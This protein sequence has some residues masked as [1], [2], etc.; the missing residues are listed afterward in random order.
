[1]V[2]EKLVSL[3]T[4]RLTKT[5]ITV[6]ELNG[7]LRYWEQTKRCQFSKCL[8]HNQESFG[9][10]MKALRM[11]QRDKQKSIRIFWILH[12]YYFHGQINQPPLSTFKFSA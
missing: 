6:I 11:L 10:S 5:S 7:Y 4:V 8:R 2:F 12:H 3:L 9:W 1:M